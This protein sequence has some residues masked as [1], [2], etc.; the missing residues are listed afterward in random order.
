MYFESL[1]NLKVSHDYQNVV[2]V[3]ISVLIIS[4]TKY[5]CLF[6]SWSY[7]DSP[8]SESFVIVIVT[9]KH[10]PT[11]ESDRERHP[12][13]AREA[14]REAENAARPGQRYESLW[15]V[16]ISTNSEVCNL[17]PLDTIIVYPDTLICGDSLLDLASC[18]LVRLLLLR[19]LAGMTAWRIKSGNILPRK[20]R[21]LQ[22]Y[23][24]ICPV[25]SCGSM[26]AGAMSI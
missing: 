6:H 20:M 11:R 16:S 18:S 7:P 24:V 26:S 9:G 12:G 10:W 4:C 23:S 13:K 17:H 3:T 5:Q 1:V 22:L 19:S 21:A 2:I 8:G 15:G 25:Y 14:H